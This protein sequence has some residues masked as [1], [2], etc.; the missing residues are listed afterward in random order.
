MSSYLPPVVSGLLKT[1]IVDEGSREWFTNCLFA[2]RSVSEKVWKKAKENKDFPMW[3]VVRDFFEKYSDTTISRRQGKL[4]YRLINESVK[5][6]PLSG[7]GRDTAV[8]G[9]IH[10]GVVDGISHGEPEHPL[11]DIA[12]FLAYSDKWHLV[13]SVVERVKHSGFTSLLTDHVAIRLQRER[14]DPDGLRQFVNAL[15][16]QTAEDIKEHLKD[17]FNKDA[18]GDYV[19]FNR[20]IEQ[21]RWVANKIGK[22][23][24]IASNKKHSEIFTETVQLLMNAE[25]PDENYPEISMLWLIATN[26]QIKK[27]EKE[28]K[29]SEV[30][31]KNG[32]SPH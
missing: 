23:S 10:Y 25:I 27:I 31:A 19:D 7:H 32:M 26:R 21:Y 28:R 3:E 17:G 11:S 24:Q 9:A 4:L 2:H 12:K 22:A 8:D 18:V 13:S 6:H 15:H 20:L 1:L 30:L 5:S 16:I 29:V 14:K